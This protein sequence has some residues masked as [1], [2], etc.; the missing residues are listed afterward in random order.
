MPIASTFSRWRA[1]RN[2]LSVT[3]TPEQ[4]ID[5]FRLA[6]VSNYPFQG[7][8]RCYRWLSRH[9]RSVALAT[10][11]AVAAVSYLLALLF[12]FDLTWPEPYGH[13]FLLTLPAVVVTRAGCAWAFRL[14]ALRWRFVGTRDVLRL[15][16]AVAAGTAALSTVM[17]LGIV[18]RMPTS[19][20]G[21]EALLTSYLTAGVWVAYRA[22][23]ERMRRH[24]LGDGGP[25]RRVLI[26][27]AGEAGNLLA[28]E[29]NRFPTGYRPIGFVDDDPVKWGSS[30][31]GVRVLGGSRDLAV[32]AGAAHAEEVI[33]AVPS[34]QPLDVRRLVTLCEAL[35]KPFKI[36]PGI[37]E[38]LAGDVR[39][40]QLREVRIEDLLGRKPIQLE[41]PELAADLEGQ[42]VLITGAAGS[43]G[44]ELARQVAL[45]Q[46][47]RLVLLDQAETELF[48][49]ELELTERHPDLTIAPVVGDVVRT[50]TVEYVFRQYAP[51]RVFHAAAYKHV[52]MM[53]VNA[54]EALRNNVIGTWRVAS[55]AGRHGTERFV[56]VSTDKAVRPSSVMG[57]TK[58]LAELATL[59]LQRRH[60]ET[61]FAAVRFGNVLGSN[62]SVIPIFMRQLEEGRPL[63]VTHA[64][65]TR[66]FMT[67]PEAVQLILQASL[68]P[69]LRGHIAMLEMGDPVR[70]V[71]LARNLIR[72]SRP[73]R[74]EGEQIIYTGLRPGEKLHEE[75]IAPD[76]DTMDTLIPK[77]RLVVPGPNN[78][79]DIRS[80]I[81]LWERA[82]ADGEREAMLDLLLELFPALRP[83][84]D[85]PP[86]PRGEL[87]AEPVTAGK[88]DG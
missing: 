61:A 6:H 25:E 22:G 39:L 57:A 65:A 67:I 47:R 41:L 64:D 28:H 66:Y 38:V 77:V 9:R 3:T 58:R 33:L 76:E 73:R 70:I 40:T 56:L 74:T 27:G 7:W 35:D 63:T 54:A 80:S 87:L 60:P 10:Y 14:A 31:Q 71:D 32:I 36:L 12:R 86:A 43:I 79:V 20:L 55:A 68:L 17:G 19:V 16:L 45:H 23:F 34:A 37:T 26:I 78:G 42:A 29:M 81:E 48:Y 1:P 11:A 30:V 13:R 46:P 4:A 88:R 21:I 62:G 51:S 49:L 18:P 8:Q 69:E 53:E 15:I 5:D 82:D 83:G 50:A 75:L 44:S 59:D 84:S 2:A 72:M 85:G 52:P 24:R